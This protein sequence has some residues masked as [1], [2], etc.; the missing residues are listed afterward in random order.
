MVDVLDGSG[1]GLGSGEGSGAGSGTG[2]GAGSWLCGG[3]VSTS[4][5]TKTIN[6]KLNYQ[7]KTK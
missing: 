7:N 2:L 3:V 5:R 6:K 4:T 1:S